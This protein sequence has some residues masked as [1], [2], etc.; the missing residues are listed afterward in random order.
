MKEPNLRDLHRKIGI[1]IA[2]FVILQTGSGLIINITDLIT[3][4][5]HNHETHRE[6]DD[7]E[8]IDS[9]LEWIHHGEGLMGLA[10]RTGVGSGFCSWH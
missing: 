6:E 5:E 4:H 8:E 7:R 9:T 1:M 10:Y 2:F 3:P